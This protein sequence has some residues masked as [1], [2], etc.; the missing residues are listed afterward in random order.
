MPL[1]TQQQ[2]GT[3]E[4]LPLEQQP[5]QTSAEQ[6]SVPQASEAESKARLLGWVPQEEFKGDKMQWRD[7]ETFLRVG[8]EHKGILRENVN[9]LQNEVQRLRQELED[10]DRTMQEFAA[11]KN[12]A[13]TR[14]LERTKGELERQLAEA[15]KNGDGEQATKLLA[16]RDKLVAAGQQFVARQQPQQQQAPDPSFQPW[17][18][19][20]PWYGTDRDLTAYADKMGRFLRNVEGDRTVGQEFLNKIRDEV[21]ARFPSKFQQQRV[22]SPDSGGGG[23]E[24]RS[25]GGKSYY[26]LPSDAKAACDKFVK[27]GLMKREDY[28][29]DYF[30]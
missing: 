18:Q 13:E 3:Q 12:N 25:A 4:Q 5:A 24:Q 30:S 2:E 8:E 6:Q 11:F 23:G 19:E 29:K 15:I 22:Q 27:Q 28:V 17:A 7:A 20:N 21:K 16:D 10:K 26:D 14:A 1:D 9:K